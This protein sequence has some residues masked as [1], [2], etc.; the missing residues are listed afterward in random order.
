MTL[1]DALETD[2]AMFTS[3]SDFGETVTYRPRLVSERNIAAVVTR[4]QAE[5]ISGDENRVATV[6]EVHVANNS[7]TGIATTEIDL[8]GDMIDIADR[9]GKTPK[10]RSILQILDQDEGMVVLRCQ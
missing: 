5:Q 3:T 1:R 4:Q 7:T 8:G 2:A 10:P 6:F 9:V